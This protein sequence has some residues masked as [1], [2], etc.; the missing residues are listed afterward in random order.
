MVRVHVPIV[1]R[2]LILLLLR[3]ASTEYMLPYTKQTRTET[4]L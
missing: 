3:C 1:S 4:P 2:Q